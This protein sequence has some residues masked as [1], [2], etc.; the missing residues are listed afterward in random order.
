MLERR[1]HTRAIATALHEP[2]VYR[3]SWLFA[4]CSWTVAA[5]TG[6]IGPQNTDIIPMDETGEEAGIGEHSAGNTHG[7]GAGDG[8]G[9]ATGASASESV[10]DGDGD[11]DQDTGT[12]D[13]DDGGEGSASDSDPE[14]PRLFVADRQGV[15]VWNDLQELAVDRPPDEGLLE[16]PARAWAITVAGDDLLVATADDE[17]SLLRYADA[18]AA[19][20]SIPPTIRVPVAATQGPLA[21]VDEFRVDVDGTLWLS[22]GATRRFVDAE[23]ISSESL[24]NSSYLAGTQ[25][26]SSVALMA[27]GQT[28]FGAAGNEGLVAWSD[29]LV[30]TADLAFDW[31]LDPS[32][33][34]DR[35]T[36]FSDRLIAGGDPSTGLQIWDDISLLTGPRPADHILPA[37]PP[38][39][40]VRDLHL[41]GGTLAVCSGEA[42][43][44][45]VLIYDDVSSLDGSSSPTHILSHPSLVDARQAILDRYG[46]LYVRG[47]DTIVIFS[48]LESTPAHR[49]SIEMSIDEPVDIHLVEC[50]ATTACDAGSTC[51]HGM[52]RE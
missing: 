42:E 26:I 47:L 31:S 44:S 9:E 38:L 2:L 8:G 34:A 28:L 23:Q 36:I 24:A 6:C 48:G 43:Q 39:A 22:A 40:R 12:G 20:A 27:T 41:R 19:K 45:S 29:P 33:R 21:G 16:L 17:F 10:G 4:L 11:G 3:S 50:S 5:S 37:T 30:D 7:S 49:L 1:T 13:E 46:N 51:V 35:I 14:L 32:S 52:C 25:A 18:A 15:A